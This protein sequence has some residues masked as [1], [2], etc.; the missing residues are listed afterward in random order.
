MEFEVDKATAFGFF[1]DD[2][3]ATNASY[4]FVIWGMDSGP[5][6]GLLLVAYFHPTIKY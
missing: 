6:K 2:Y 1:P 5:S 3:H 4:L